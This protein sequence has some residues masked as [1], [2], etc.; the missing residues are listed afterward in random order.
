[1]DS[2]SV[3]T[4]TE[5][6]FQPEVLSSL[7]PV[8]V[9]FW[10]PWCGPCRLIAP[11][12]ESLAADFAGQV[13]I[14]KLNIDQFDR[15]ATQYQVQAIPTLL[16]FKDGQVVDEIVGVVPKAEL[17]KKLSSVLAYQP[18]SQAA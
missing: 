4:L 2:T 5:A 13:K 8:L 10:A 14:A 7:Q 1:M 17:A 18:A 9:D 15:L 6:N 3:I 16:I 11:I 12:V